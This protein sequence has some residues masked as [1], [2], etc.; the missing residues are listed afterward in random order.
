MTPV[1]YHGILLA[2][3]KRVGIKSRTHHDIQVK[4]FEIL[5]MLSKHPT[6]EL[7]FKHHRVECNSLYVNS[8]LELS[9]PFFN[10]Y[11]QLCSFYPFL[12][13]LRTRCSPCELTT[14]EILKYVCPSFS[15]SL[16]TR[17]PTCSST[18]GKNGFTRPG[19]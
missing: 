5:F 16:Y 6:G 8:D 2:R 9:F 11:H 14:A 15:V 7:Y 4:S 13:C 19:S 18:L 12:T 1:K 17:P 10:S 3:Q